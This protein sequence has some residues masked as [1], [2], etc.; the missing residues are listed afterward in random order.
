MSIMKNI[1]FA[2]IVM[3]YVML[4][5]C[6]TS[7]GSGPVIVP[8]DNIDG[9][10]AEVEFIL[11]KLDIPG[12]SIAV[13]NDYE[14]VESFAIGVIDQDT[15]QLVTEQTVFQAASISKTIA[16]IAIIKWAADNQIALDS[17]VNQL[18]R[19]WYLPENGLAEQHKASIE[20][21]LRH[22][23][24]I[25]VPG[26]PGYNRNTTLPTLDQILN[27]S[28]LTKT[29][30]IKL[31]TEPTTQWKY[32]GG[33]YTVLQKMVE[34]QTGLRFQEFMHQQIIEFL[35]LDNST[36]EQ[37]NNLDNLVRSGGHVQGSSSID[38]E[39]HIY[40]EL[41]AAGF[42]SNAHDL[43]QIAIQLQLALKSESDL[44]TFEQVQQMLTSTVKSTYGMGLELFENGYFGHTGANEGFRSF[45][46]LNR[47]GYGLVVLTN[48]DDAEQLMKSLIS[49][50]GDKYNQ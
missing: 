9:T 47:S 5:G 50:F 21:I 2:L 23:A 48:S 43:A 3:F 36:F 44:L 15:Q 28:S 26:F 13:I 6:G 20:N 46:R 4:T 37:D 11:S 42:W 41:A 38:G 7:D 35:A 17:D 12:V 10:L 32:S 29:D 1:G 39:Y 31:I 49:L 40:P 19:S 33:G 45:M 14:I 24:G 25:N 18:L 27:G 22:S 34:D 30:A 8:P 16:A